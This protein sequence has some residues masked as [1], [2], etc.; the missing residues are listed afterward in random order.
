MWA[1]VSDVRVA[2]LAVG[3]KEGQVKSEDYGRDIASVQ[4]LLSKQVSPTTMVYLARPQR[5][6]GG[7]RLLVLLYK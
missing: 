4:A 1:G 3:S 5:L 7:C 2:V 6:I